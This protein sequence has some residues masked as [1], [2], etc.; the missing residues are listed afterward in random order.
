MTD[1]FVKYRSDLLMYPQ[2]TPISA[3]EC[4]IMLLS[5]A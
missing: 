1:G 2:M 3:E 5:T 4:R